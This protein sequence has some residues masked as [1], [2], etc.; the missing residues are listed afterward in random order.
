MKVIGVMT[1]HNRKDKTL[2]SIKTLIE[3]NPEIDFEFIVVDD[4][5]TDGTGELLKKTFPMVTVISGTGNLFYSGGMRV[6]I[7]YVKKE[8]K[9]YDF[10]L[11]FNDD[12]FF[13]KKCIQRMI[14]YKKNDSIVVG[15]TENDS[16]KLSYGGV[17]KVSAIRPSFQIFMSIQ[18][19]KEYC[20]TFN[21]NCVLIDREVFIVLNNIDRVYRHSL[22]DY[23]YGLNAT[24]NGYKICVTDFFV[25]HCN[26][27][28]VTDNWLDKGKRRI[29]RIKEKENIKGLPTKVW[30]HFVKKNFNVVSA[31]I[32]SIIPYIRIMIKR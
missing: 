9:N 11:F 17:R 26:N 18:D 15:A 16:G 24:R 32:Y 4:G 29:D 28:P 14:N 30:F 1:C 13:Y 2:N 20:D 5:S 3:H 19:K 8:K 25:G 21:A 12:V 31:I 22:G 10:V 27:N 7:D 23:D 6:G